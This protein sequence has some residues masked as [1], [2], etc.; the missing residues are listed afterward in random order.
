MAIDYKSILSK[1]PIDLVTWLHESFDID[2][3]LEIK[4]IEDMEMASKLIL[5]LT[6]YNAYLLE[7]LSY[8]KCVT[9]LAK[10][11]L[12]KTEYEDMVDRK[13]AIQNMVDT[14]DQ[15]YKAVSR[16]VTI[17]IENNAELKINS[18]SGRFNG[19]VSG[20]S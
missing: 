15:Q 3:P 1:T 16:A 5:V 13:E 4:S 17:R 7:L 20:N 8:A 12:S 19:T 10:R 14:I 11:E 18:A 9:R 6:E 2:T